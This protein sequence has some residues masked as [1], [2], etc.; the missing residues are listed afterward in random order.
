M[1]SACN[2]HAISMQSACN[3]STKAG[4]GRTDAPLRQSACNEGGNQ[5]YR[6]PVEAGLMGAA[7]SMQSAWAYRRPV[8]AGGSVEGT[9]CRTRSR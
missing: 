9:R 3:Q 5:A 4:L 2:Q 7:I 1:Q 6:R 8:E